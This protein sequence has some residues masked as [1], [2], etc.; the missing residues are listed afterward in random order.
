MA[1]TIDYREGLADL[2]ILHKYEESEEGYSL[3]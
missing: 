3:L 2:P 1:F